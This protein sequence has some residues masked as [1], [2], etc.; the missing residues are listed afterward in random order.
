MW[1]LR[2]GSTKKLSSYSSELFFHVLFRFSQTKNKD[3]ASE[4]TPPYRARSRS[5]L[6]REQRGKRTKQMRRAV[7]GLSVIEGASFVLVI[8][9]AAEPGK[10]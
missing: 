4:E 2:D 9:M 6:G 3:K 5:R 7:E 8:E 1:S 10:Y